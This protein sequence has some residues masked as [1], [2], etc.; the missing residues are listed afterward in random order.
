MNEKEKTVPGGTEKTVKGLEIPTF[1]LTDNATKIKSK[2]LA[3]ARKDKTAKEV[4]QIVKTIY[5][6]YD[7][8]LQS[9]VE[10]GELYGI[11]LRADALRLLA[12]P[13]PKKSRDA[14]KMSRRISARLPEKMHDKLLATIK[15][16]GFE[17]VQSWLTYIVTD[18]LRKET[19]K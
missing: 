3:E 16:K 9:K 11:E 18:Y 17:S 10:H 6:R 2:I 15:G 8:Q 1:I 12:D 14:H 7:K 13:A 19:A 4:V 5:P